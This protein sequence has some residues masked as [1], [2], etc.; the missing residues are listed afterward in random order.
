MRF[1]FLI[2]FCTAS[3]PQSAVADDQSGGDRSVFYGTWGSA[4]Q[5]AKSP[6]KP[7]GT[8]LF[9]PYEINRGWLRHGQQWCRLNW[10][11]VEKRENGFFTGANA[12][13]GEDSVRSYFLGMELSGNELKLRWNFL[14]VNGPLQRC[15]D[16]T[17]TDEDK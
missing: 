5:C 15:S 6:I 9:E 2:A 16:P 17:I 1:A 8:V 4:K 11:P 12:Q 7:G 3:I 10:G 13:C 14:R